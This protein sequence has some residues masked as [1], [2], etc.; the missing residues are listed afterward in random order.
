LCARW[1]TG[2]D[3]FDR[4]ANKTGATGDKHA[5]LQ[6]MCWFLRTTCPTG[7]S[8]SLVIVERKLFQKNRISPIFLRNRNSR[9]LCNN[10]VVT[11]LYGLYQSWI[12][13][14]RVLL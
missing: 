12:D 3:T 7:K 5:D 6:N 10:G 4:F 8:A 14:N 13:W 9:L 1:L 2:D 11:W